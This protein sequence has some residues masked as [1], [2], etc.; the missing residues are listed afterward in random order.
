MPQQMQSGG[1]A[2][3][4][5]QS[6][7]LTPPPGTARPPG[8]WSAQSPT[9]ATLAEADATDSGR[10]L[11][12]FYVEGELGVQYLAPEAFHGPMLL[13]SSKKSDIGPSLGAGFGIRL[14]Y[15]TVGPHVRYAPFSSFR[16]LTVDLDLGW[17][18]P[19]GR[20]EPYAILAAGYCALGS[21]AKP[22]GDFF[23]WNLR[24][25]GGIDYYVSNVL[26]VGGSMTAEI[27]R[28]R[29]SGLDGVP[30]QD[31]SLQPDA[32]GLGIGLT[33]SGVVGLHF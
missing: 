12:F 27:V 7:G 2:P 19:L 32:Y 8:P 18:V 4:P 14:L 15:F 5:M 28:L 23:G 13:A 21:D 11:D 20:L 31:P 33:L 9:A 6:G 3:P 10:G 22:G 26:S 1:L 17:H 25:G 30:Q 16:L 24:L 29:I